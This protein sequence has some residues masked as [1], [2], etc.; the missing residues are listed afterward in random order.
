MKRVTLTFDNGPTPLVTSFVLDQLGQRGLFGLFC[1]V[2]KQLTNK[3]GVELARRELAEGHRIINHSLTHGVALGVDPTKEHATKEIVE[4]DELLTEKLGDWGD[5]WFRPFGQ[6][7]QLGP[8]VFSKASLEQLTSLR[9]SVLLWNSVPRDWEC[10]NTW[11]GHA[12]HDI[13]RLEHTVVVLHDLPTGAMRELPRFLDEL[14]DR[15]ICITA[16]LPVECVPLRDGVVAW[17]AGE[18]DKLVSD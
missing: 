12:L 16:D 14:R 15:N 4:M 8:H 2:G 10:P 18:L 5:K 11:V 9:Y 3:I 13:S 1:L 6:G 17:P 7:G